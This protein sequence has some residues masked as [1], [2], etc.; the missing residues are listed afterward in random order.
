MHLA[1]YTMIIIDDWIVCVCVF[2]LFIYRINCIYYAKYI[3]L[4]DAA[5]TSNYNSTR[6]VLANST[7]HS[8][9]NIVNA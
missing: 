8:N 6:L 5:F 9:Y 4:D 3:L 1:A 2:L 7:D